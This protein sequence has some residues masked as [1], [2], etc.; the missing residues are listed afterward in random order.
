MELFR[1]LG[2]LAEPPSPE[3]TRLAALLELGE[4]PGAGDY[5]ALFLLELSP[6]ASIYLGH[7]GMVGGEARD[8]IAGFWRAL[9]LEPP[10]EPDHLALMLGLY[11]RLAELEAGAT[12]ADAQRWRHARRAWLWEH[13]ASWLP[14]Y[15][16]A[17]RPVAAPFYAGWGAELAAALVAEAERL[18]SPE[19]PPLHLREAARPAD[20]RRDGGAAFLA[21]LLSPVRSGMLLLAGDLRR[22]CGDL[23]LGG[24]IGERRFVLEAMLGQDAART[25]DW[26]AAHARHWSGRLRE[27]PA[28]LEPVIDHWRRRADATA[29]LL[30]ELAGEVD[31]PARA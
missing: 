17:L 25:L 1:A 30:E 27:Q 12:G 23:G 2:T 29:R 22:A 20:P 21:S 5:D 18:E 4:P 13:L 11:A 15:L 28:V 10:T 26:L 16:E 8:R 6:Y 14:A 19:H 7:E 3:T 31:A 9:G 24:R